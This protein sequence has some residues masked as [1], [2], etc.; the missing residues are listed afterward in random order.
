MFAAFPSFFGIWGSSGH[1]PTFWLLLWDTLS[2]DVALVK[3]CID[4][5]AMRECQLGSDPESL[6]ELGLLLIC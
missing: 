1:V 5:W 4:I 6:E 3:G 2:R